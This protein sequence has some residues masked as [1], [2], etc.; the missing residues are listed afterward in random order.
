MR[1]M[2]GRVGILTLVIATV[3]AMVMTAPAYAKAPKT[4]KPGHPS[5]VVALPVERGSGGFVDGAT[6]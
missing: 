4:K 5:G 1:R 3:S 2:L 6:V